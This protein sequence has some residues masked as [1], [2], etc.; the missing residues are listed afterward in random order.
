MCKYTLFKSS[1]TLLI[2]SESSHRRCLT[3]VCDC[4]TRRHGLEHAL[5]SQLYLFIGILQVWQL[6][7]W[8]D[9]PEDALVQF[10]FN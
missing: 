7:E 5:P 8:F 9:S 3:R 6:K 10:M 4:C 1:V 2:T